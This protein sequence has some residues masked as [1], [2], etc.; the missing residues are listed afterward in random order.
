MEIIYVLIVAYGFGLQILTKTLSPLR[1]IFFYGI[2]GYMGFTYGLETGLYTLVAV[3]AGQCIA[4][5]NGQTR[6]I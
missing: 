1:T 2:I 3:I 4:H 5:F 6:S